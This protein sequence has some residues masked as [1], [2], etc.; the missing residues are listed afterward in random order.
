MDISFTYDFPWY[1]PLVIFFARI[2][3]MSLGTVRTIMIV[4]GRKWISG[5]IALVEITV[6][7]LAIGGLVTNL[8]NFYI[9]I[10]YAGG[11]ATGTIVGIYLEEWLALGLR[12]IRFINRASDSNLCHQL[13]EE[14]YRVTR[15]E[16]T[17][18]EGPV[19]IGFTVIRRADLKTC[20]SVIE[21]L[22]PEAWIT[23]EPVDRAS[24]GSIS[25][26]A[27]A[28]RRNVFGRRTSLRK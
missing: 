11:F 7:V 24:I 4:S 13:R 2:T 21:Q 23:V 26:D 6:W 8:K 12:V 16:G 3:D 27:A 18:R 20:Q 10:A 28:K 1:L 19:E 14:G 5:V 17:G 22:A 9:L 15:V 25:Y